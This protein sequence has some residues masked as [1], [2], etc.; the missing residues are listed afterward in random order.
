[1]SKMDSSQ[2]PRRSIFQYDPLEETGMIRLLELLPSTNG[3]PHARVSHVKVLDAPK[4]AA[5]SYTWGVNNFDHDLHID[6]GAVLHIT[7]NLS[8][9][10]L[11]LG[12]STME[13]GLKLWVDAV[14][15]N[16]K[17][18][19]ERG[20]QVS[21]MDEIYKRS[22]RVLVWLGKYYDESDLAMDSI[23]KWT[24]RLHAS[25]NGDMSYPALH[26]AL[27]DLTSGADS[28]VI[29]P[30]AE[31]AWRAILS[32]WER[33]WWRRAWI[34]QEA[35][36]LPLNRVILH[37]GDRATDLTRMRNILDIRYK[38]YHKPGYEYLISNFEQGFADHLDILNSQLERGPLQ[39]VS[40]LNYGRTYECGDERD[41]VFAVRSIASD[42]PRDAMRPNYKKSLAEVYVDVA[43][44]LVDV[45]TDGNPLKFLGLVIRP[46]ENWDR[47][48]LPD[49]GV[50]SWVPDWR[51][52]KVDIVAFRQ[53]LTPRQKDVPSYKASGDREPRFS[54]DGVRLRIDGMIVDTITES[55]P[56]GII[57]RQSNF[58]VERAWLPPNGDAA[59]VA[60]GTL[61]EAI[62]HCIIAD[63]GR[64]N[65]VIVAAAKDDGIFER[66][67]A[68]DWDLLDRSAAGLSTIEAKRQRYLI[69]DIKCMSTGRRIFTTAQGYI[70]LGPAAA[71]VGDKVCVFLGGR[72]LHVM[73]PIDDGNFEYVGECYVHGMMDGEALQACG[74]TSTFAVL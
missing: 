71:N 68:V 7:Q 27:D 19:E 34:V 67:V 25:R 56:V 8:D 47:L 73:R 57:T 28:D 36:A 4:Y 11:Q 66:G 64:V 63:M 3:T 72:M 42:V 58:S 49:N 62:K 35:T 31:R 65:D 21:F 51:G 74:Q 14:C 18:L 38:L 22:D 15:V 29:G 41:K 20:S 39:F 60:G 48:M 1:M 70:G 6:D 59:Y 26:R 40:I 43:R 46:T 12:P 23:E 44:F 52:P 30:V 2:L 54:I 37:A 9:A 45:T 33:P 5:L 17:D 10:L 69:N 50:P 32:L 13:R 53:S 55:Q 61:G 24:T 16:Q